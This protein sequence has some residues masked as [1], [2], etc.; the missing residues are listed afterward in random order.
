MAP[1]EGGG[2]SAWFGADATEDAVFDDVSGLAEAAA[3][4]VETVRDGS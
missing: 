4:T 1:S 3:V 2:D